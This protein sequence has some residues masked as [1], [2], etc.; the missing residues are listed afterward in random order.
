MNSRPQIRVE[1]QLDPLEWADPSHWRAKALSAAFSSPHRRGCEEFYFWDITLCTWW[2]SFEIPE[3][4]LPAS[5]C[6][7][8]WLYFDRKN[9]DNLFLRNVGWLSQDY[10]ITNLFKESSALIPIVSSDANVFSLEQCKPLVWFKLAAPPC[11]YV[12]STWVG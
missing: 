12:L 1:I 8:A 3:K 10:M 4:H 11:L 6:F 7:L 5:C 2:K 9:G